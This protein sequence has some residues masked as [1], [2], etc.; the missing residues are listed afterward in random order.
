VRNV[1]LHEDLAVLEPAMASTIDTES[2]TTTWDWTRPLRHD[3]ETSCAT[4]GRA[5]VMTWIH[6]LGR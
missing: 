1:E 6:G 2:P 3:R 4:T 5:T